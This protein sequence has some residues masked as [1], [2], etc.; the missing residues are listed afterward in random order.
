[1]KRRSLLTGVVTGSIAVIGC[2]DTS[3]LSGDNSDPTR[4][5]E[6]IEHDF[7]TGV[8]TDAKSGE[9]PEITVNR[10]EST[11][12]VEGVGEYGDP[13]CEAL[14]GR[15]PDYD[16]ETAELYVRAYG[17]LKPSADNRDHCAD[18]MGMS[19]YRFV[20]RFDEGVPAKIRAKHPFDQQATKEA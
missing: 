3:K 17:A 2:L 16:P 15:D 20:I 1:M 13:S 4:P 18:T 12:T 6:I 19:S 10:E 14:F 11:V 7:E 8:T 5:T 9:E